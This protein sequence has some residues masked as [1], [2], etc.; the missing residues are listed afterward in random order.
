MLPG[1]RVRDAGF[2]FRFDIEIA[3]RFGRIESEF[4]CCFFRGDNER[5][6]HV[7]DDVLRIPLLV[8]ET[9]IERILSG[10][11]DGRGERNGEAALLSFV[12]R[13][14]RDWVPPGGG[15]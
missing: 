9:E 10:A 2:D 3:Y 1:K 12:E 5:T 8:G 14:F 11:E 4:R 7:V 13:V 15:D 6:G